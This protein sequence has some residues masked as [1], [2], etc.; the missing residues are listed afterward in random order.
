[1]NDEFDEILNKAVE[2][3]VK[4]G[5]DMEKTQVN[6]LLEKLESEEGKKG[7]AI[8]ILHIMRQSARG[9]IQK[10]TARELVAFLKKILETNPTEAKE[11]A[12]EFLGIIK[13]LYEANE[14]LK[15]QETEL[16]SPYFQ[17]Y[18]EAFIHKKN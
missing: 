6:G 13:W 12:R 16:K 3:A 9:R 7:V 1:M 8:L 17:S 11:K 10:K 14:N 2:I 15:V 18:L 4:A 5:K